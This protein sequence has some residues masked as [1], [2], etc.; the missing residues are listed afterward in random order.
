MPAKQYTSGKSKKNDFEQQLDL[1]FPEGVLSLLKQICDAEVAP[2]VKKI[3]RNLGKKNRLRPKIVLALQ[4]IIRTSEILWLSFSMPIEKWI[5]PEG[6]WLLLSEVS[7]YLHEAVDWEFLHHHWQLLNR[8]GVKGPNSDPF[9]CQDLF[10]E[11]N[12]VDSC[13]FAPAGDSVYLLQT[14]ANVSLKLP[15]EAAA[16]MAQNLLRRIE[17]FNLDPT[18]VCN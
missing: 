11:N 13:S 12:A 17:E 8:G 15:A 3:C 9:T 5:A 10:E 7:T 14:I 2:W 18:E 6:A 1:L 16:D 4:D